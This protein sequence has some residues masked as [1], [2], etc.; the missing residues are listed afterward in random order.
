M[1]RLL[2]LNR[3]EFSRRLEIS[4]YFRD[5]NYY[6]DASNKDDAMIC[7]LSSRINKFP[8]ISSLLNSQKLS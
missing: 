8:L 7:P 5:V 1:M 2:L 4:F 6:E 3:T